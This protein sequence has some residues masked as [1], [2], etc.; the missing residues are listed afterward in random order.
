M[1][2]KNKPLRDRKYLDSMRDEACYACGARDGTVVGAHI[3]HGFFG[4]GI[5]PDDSLALPLCAAD[6]EVQHRIG[7][8]S[9][10]AHYLKMPKGFEGVDAAKVRARERYLKW[11]EKQ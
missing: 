4:I 2:P 8:I 1:I 10:W 5:K 9:F 3:R 6:H 7:E 11:K